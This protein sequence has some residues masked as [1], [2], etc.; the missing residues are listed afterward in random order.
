MEE[1]YNPRGLCFISFER[2]SYILIYPS[3]TQSYLDSPST[4]A[5]PSSDFKELS[6]E[7]AALLDQVKSRL[8]EVFIIFIAYN[9]LF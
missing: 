9:Y 8:D 5:L 7:D 6:Q 3:S 1:R 2:F 4:Q